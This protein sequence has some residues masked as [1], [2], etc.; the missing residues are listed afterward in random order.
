M[1][2]R[3]SFFP[4]RLLNLLQVHGGTLLCAPRRST[5]SCIVIPRSLTAKRCYAFF[6]KYGAIRA[7]F[8]LGRTKDIGWYPFFVDRN[9]D[10][11]LVRGG[12][13]SRFN[14]ANVYLSVV[15]TSRTR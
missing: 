14:C 12:Y 3:F 4:T 1:F 7:D 10:M 5:E 8:G 13:L 15:R 11:M 6:G 9:I 2:S